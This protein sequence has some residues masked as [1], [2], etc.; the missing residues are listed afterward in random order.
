MSNRRRVAARSVWALVLSAVG[1]LATQGCTTFET[2][3]A[4]GAGT[5]GGGTSA[6]TGAGTGS[7]G[8]TGGGI[9]GSDAGHESSRCA[10]DDAGITCD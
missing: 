7:T 4:G 6:S 5:G 9:G 10:I 8:S 3:P 2:T 1:A